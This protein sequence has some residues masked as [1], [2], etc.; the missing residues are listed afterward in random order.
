VYVTNANGNLYGTLLINFTLV[1]AAFVVTG[2]RAL[3]YQ[4][5]MQTNLHYQYHKSKSVSSNLKKLVRLIL[6][7]VLWVSYTFIFDVDLWCFG[8]CL[9]FG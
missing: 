7:I 5:L 9:S 1:Y 2:I 4:Q 8:H 3:K 6:Y